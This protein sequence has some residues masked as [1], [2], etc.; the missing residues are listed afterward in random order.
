[1]KLTIGKKMLGGFLSVSL[2]LGIISFISYYNIKKV[3]ESYSDLVERRVIILSN[4]KDM[5]ISAS[6]QISGMRGVLMQEEGSSEIV[7]TAIND[8]SEK[9]NATIQI[10]QREELKAKLQKLQI[11]NADFKSQ[12]DAIIASVRSNPEQA[13][14]QSNQVLFPLAREIRDMSDQIAN[15]QAKLMEEASAANRQLVDSVV[16]TV[17]FLSVFACI[18]AVLIGVYITRI[19][20]KPILTIAASAKEISSGI[21]TG[22][23]IKVKNRDEIAD[24]ANSFNQ[25]KMNLRHLIGQVS[26][27]AKQ[28]SATSHDLFE[29]AEQTS[30]A[31][32]QISIAIQEV[33]LG[34]EKQVHSAAEANQAA[35]EILR[36]MNQAALSIQS[37]ADLTTTANEKATAGNKVVTQAMEQMNVMQRS[38]GHTAEVMNA[39]G[40]KSKEIGHIVQLITEISNQT[41]LLA[42][43]AAIEAAR[44]GEHGRGFAVVADEVR[45]LAE[46]SGDA[47]GQI[48]QL[49]GEVQA[50]ADKAVQSMDEGATV[51][52]EG[53]QMVH[54]SG[55]AFRD[56]VK[57]IEQVAAESQEVSA[58]IEQVNSSSQSMAEMMEGVAHIAEQSAGNTQNVAASAEE[59][60]ASMEEISASAE[61]LS[62][63]AQDLQE[64]IS[65]FKV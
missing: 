32:E 23:D 38:V 61:S 63:M 28:V 20:K 24:L 65:K 47:A 10:V 44:A 41:N 18:L 17:L 64:M 27:N 62:K 15:E 34:S 46:Q 16:T 49:I 1:M 11:L 25:M 12:S 35:A 57:A 29:S 5:Q 33:A 59:Q 60:N 56:I 9:I 7:A 8:L 21:L 37:V 26:N 2:L 43:N 48:R 52:L 36:G 31:T 6:R 45:K 30:K 22:D 3:D 19:I 4:A 55:E 40:E 13:V 54:Q 42:L 39:L 14:R 58:I 50:E 53:I 51:I